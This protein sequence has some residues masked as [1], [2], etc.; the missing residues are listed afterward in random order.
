MKE[1]PISIRNEI[2]KKNQEGESVN[3]LSKKYGIS[4]Y[5]IQSWCGLQPEVNV[6]QIIPL[7]RGRKVTITLQEY[8]YENKCL[9]MENELLWDFLH[10]SGR[11]WKRMWNIWWYIID[12]RNTQF[13]R[14]VTFSMNKYSLLSE[15]HRKKKYRT[16]GEQLHKYDNLLN[17]DFTADRP[18]QKWVTDISY[19]H[20]TQGVL[21]LSVI[22][23]LFDNSIVAHRTDTTLKQLPIS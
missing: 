17:R 21:Y 22:R 6:R 15:I 16:M 8:R 11:K 18:N 13:K 12:G 14:C 1:Y 9:R 2:I 19:I 23:D 7:K 20:T 10:L 5:A 4:R 3:S